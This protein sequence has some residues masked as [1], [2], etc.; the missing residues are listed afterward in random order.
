M[1][2]FVHMSPNAPAVDI[3][4]AD[5]KKLFTNISFKQ[6]TDYIMVTPGVYGIQVRLAGTN[7]IV[8]TVPNVSIQGGIPYSIYAIGLAGGKPPLAAVLVEDEL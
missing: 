5:G 6:A 2:K 8:L 1:V 3:T 4:L 7:T